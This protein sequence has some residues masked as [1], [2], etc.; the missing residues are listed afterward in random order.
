[1]RKVTINTKVATK[2]DT[3]VDTR[4]DT[5]N[6]HTISMEDILAMEASILHPQQVLTEA[7]PP[8]HSPQEETLPTFSQ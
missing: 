8:A 7:I 6:L 1:M 4:V 5:T 2:V 3:K